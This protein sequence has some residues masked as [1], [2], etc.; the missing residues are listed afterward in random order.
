MPSEIQEFYIVTEAGSCIYSKSSQAQIDQTLFAGF[1]TA[2]NS[3]SK[4]IGKSGIDGFSLG[5][6][7]FLIYATHK[8]LFVARTEPNAKDGTVRR[9]LRE[10][11]QIFFHRFPPELF[12]KDW[13]TAKDLFTP[14][15]LDYNAFFLDKVKV[16]AS[17]LGW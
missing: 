17:L 12:E 14:L 6:S 1:L 3:F 8:L 4:Q 9:I 5:K 13:D 11:V 15:D 7:K 2:L 16:I 10:M